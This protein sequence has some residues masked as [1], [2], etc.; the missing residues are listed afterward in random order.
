MEKTNFQSILDGKE[1]ELKTENIKWTR[2]EQAHKIIMLI[3]I[4]FSHQCEPPVVFSSL[5]LTGTMT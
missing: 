2:D 4:F 5:L 1:A 3:K